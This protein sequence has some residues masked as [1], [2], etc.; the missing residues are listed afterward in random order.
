VDKHGSRTDLALL[1]L[2]LAFAAL[3]LAGRVEPYGLFHDELYYWACALRPGLG[4]VD[5]PPLAP[6]VLAGSTAVFGEGRLGFGIVPALCGA[7]TVFLTGLMARR[8]GAGGWGQ[9]LAG[10]CAGV[11][12]VFLVFSSFF[13]VNAIEILLWTLACLLLLELVRTGNERV[14]LAFGLVAGLGLLNKHTFALLAL[15]L[16]VG[17]LATPLRSRLRSPW[18][19]LGAVLALALA[20][21]NLYW[22]WVH[23]WPSLAFYRS[24]PAADVPASPVQALVLVLVGMNPAS[25]LVWGAGVFFLLRS[26]EARPQRAFGV[27]FLVLLTVILFSGQRRVDRIAG[28][29]PIA[30]AAGAAFWERWQGRGRGV[31]RFGLPALVA[32]FGALVLPATLPLLPPEATARYLRAFGDAPDIETADVGVELPLYLLGRLE[33][34]RLADQVASAWES[35]PADQRER[36]VILAPH[37]VF[38]SV[39]EY[40]GRDRGLPPVV[41]PHNAYWFWRADA[42][43]RDVALSVA[44][45]AEVLSRYFSETR[46][47]GIFRCEHCWSVRPDLPILVSTGPSRPVEALLEEWRHFSIEAAPGLLR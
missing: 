38:A 30:F 12:P 42:A 24:R 4:Y 36:A 46:E 21:P 9:C 39:V 18:P 45:E 35:L 37:W 19:W 15:G 43:G 5:H 11:A 14:W 41:S 1:G 25:V 16:G 31:V 33:W 6:W 8:L 40:H 2:A 23:D 29:F 34:E 26:R 28:I 17:I 22:N 3:E 13:S 44:V 7:A 27:A 47:L 10:L 32:G 20:S